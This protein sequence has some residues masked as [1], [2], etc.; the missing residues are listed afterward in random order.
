ERHDDVIEVAEIKLERQISARHPAGDRDFVSSQPGADVFVG[1]H[2][3][4]CLVWHDDHRAVA[5]AHART[6]GKKGVAIADVSERMN[7]DRGDMEPAAGRSEEHT[8][9]LQSRRG[10]VCRL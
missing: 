7:R 1:A 4:L 2:L 6:A 5:V 9:E 8:S 3:K 10:L